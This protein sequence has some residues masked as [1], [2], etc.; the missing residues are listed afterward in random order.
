MT[1]D[2]LSSISEYGEHSN[3][4]SV[5]GLSMFGGYPQSPSNTGS[6]STLASTST[7]RSY[8]SNG[9]PSEKRS[10]DNSSIMSQRIRASQGPATGQKTNYE[11]CKKVR[12]SMALIGILF[13]VAAI[14]MLSF[15]LPKQYQGK[16][17]KIVDKEQEE[18]WSEFV[19]FNADKLNVYFANNISETVENPSKISLKVN[20]GVLLTEGERR[21]MSFTKLNDTIMMKFQDVE[22]SLITLNITKNIS[23]SE[24]CF[25]V[26]WTAPHNHKLEDCFDTLS[27]HWYGLGEVLK[28]KWPLDKASFPMTGFV[29]TDFVDQFSSD[30]FGG[31]L[32]P[33]AINSKGAGLYVDEKVP[34]HI[35]MNANNKKKMCFRADPTTVYHSYDAK[36]SNILKY[37]ICIQKNIKLVHELMF[38]M[39]IEKPPRHPDLTAMK[40][41]IWSTWVRYKEEITEDKVREMA[42][43]I[44]MYKF[45]HSHFQIEGKYSDH[46]G[47][48]KFS[49]KKFDDVTGMLDILK[50][51]GF[52]VT[53]YV[54]PFADLESNAFRKGL[55]YWMSVGRRNVPGITRWWAGVG[56]ILDTTNPKAREWFLEKLKDFQ[57][58]RI[59]G[60]KF[61]TGEVSFLPDNY[62]YTTKLPNPNYY[63]KY[64]VQMASNFS[65]AEVRVGYKSQSFPIYIRLLDRISHWPTENGLKSVL[66]AVLTLSILG[67][68]YI[69]PDMVGGNAY[70]Y[71]PNQ[72]LYVRWAQLSAFLPCVQFSLPPWSFGPQSEVVEMVNEA[73]NIRKRLLPDIINA[74]TNY[75]IT[76]D[77][78]VRPLWWYWPED[79]ETFVADTE[80]MLGDKYLIAPVLNINIKTHAVYLPAGI[81]EELWGKGNTLN[82]TTGSLHHYNVTLRTICYFKLVERFSS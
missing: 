10:A 2:R 39:F 82:V 31:I 68:P 25:E 63:T 49:R 65:L 36:E 69:I 40:K 18:P 47:D 1:S 26:S 72:E 14:F 62:K 56:G 57:K 78:I 35:S 52:R 23:R 81:W 48:F 70:Y 5:T 67:Y 79:H 64:Y 43:E 3:R 38:N 42:D 29:T 20:F 37:T 73:L 16:S 61:D 80:F 45:E 77:P 9:Y 46:Y 6:I 55:K 75:S 11:F 15:Y 32:E 7:H 59:D 71:T 27:S 4:T 13:L 12:V 17:I 54:S 34:L 76:G 74:A 53:V 58:L 41:P 44:K 8:K 28:Q 60:F 66:T 50:S 22:S 24:K 51:Q 30:V 21:N 33:F 19:K